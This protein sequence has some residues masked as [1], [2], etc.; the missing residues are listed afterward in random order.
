MKKKHFF[1]MKSVMSTC[2]C[3]REKTAHQVV[4]LYCFDIDI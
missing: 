2:L 4:D 3:R 1:V